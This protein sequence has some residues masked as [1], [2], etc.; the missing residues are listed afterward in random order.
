MLDG[1]RRQARTASSSTAPTRSRSRASRRS[2]YTANGFFFVNVVGYTAR[3]LIAEHTGVYGIYA[4]NSK[5]GEM[6]D[7]EAYYDNDAGFYIGQT[8]RQVKPIRSIVRTSSP[9]AT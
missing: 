5:G 7:S 4:F 8:P 9:G 1:R 6:R 3:D 2:N